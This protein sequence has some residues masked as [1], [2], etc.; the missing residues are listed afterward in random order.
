MLSM[1]QYGRS[2]YRLFD[3]VPL[4]LLPSVTTTVTKEKIQCELPRTPIP[5][6][7]VNSVD[8]GEEES[9]CV[10][11][12]R[13]PPLLTSRYRAGA[14]FPSAAPLCLFLRACPWSP[15]PYR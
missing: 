6:T 11:Q 8:R 15:L 13:P 12:P 7:P 5:R 4:S 3:P 14:P 1:W 9:R 10:D 2:S